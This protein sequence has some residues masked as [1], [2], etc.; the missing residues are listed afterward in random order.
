MTGPLDLPSWRSE[1]LQALF[2][3]VLLLWGPR[4]S[5]SVPTALIIRFLTESPSLC[6][7]AAEVRAAIEGAW[8]AGLP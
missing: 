3:R 2:Q 1:C 4:S 7:D 6:D 5:P 8:A